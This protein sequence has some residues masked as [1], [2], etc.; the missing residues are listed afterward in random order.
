VIE[1]AGRGV[2]LD[3]EGTTTS[4]AF[5]YDTLFPYVRRSLRAFLAD[6]TADPEVLAAS[7][8]IAREAG[9]G[10]L[11]EF[12]REAGSSGDLR[13]LEPEVLRRMDV[14][15]KST[16]LKQLQGLI[17][18]AGYAC[19]EL[20]GHVYPDVP[21]ALAAWAAQGA[22]IR[23]YSSGSVEAQR[24]LFAHTDVGP[25]DGYLRGYYDTSTGPK[26][27]PESYRRIADH[28]GRDPAGVLFLSDTL[29]ELDA[30]RAAGLATAIVRRGAGPVQALH[31]IITQFGEVRL[32]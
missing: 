2:L 30:A 19:G 17:W 1:H 10:S 32:T 11:T 23:I 16:G 13:A 12:L 28:M 29:E 20:R 8:I 4:I 5:V 7:E 24:L 15:D 21:V 9:A 26:R 18:R 27:S 3:I 31:P 22:D 6:R 25:L 14:D